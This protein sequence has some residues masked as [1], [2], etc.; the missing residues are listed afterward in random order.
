SDLEAYEALISK[1]KANVQGEPLQT[2]PI[3]K[4]IVEKP[5]AEV[6]VAGFQQAWLNLKDTHEFFGL[7]GKY[8]IAR[9]QAMRLAPEEHA[10]QISIDS[11]KQ[12][13]ENVSERELEI[14]VFIG[15]RGCI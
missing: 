8:G 14:M 12:I 6:D 1:Y 7:L 4:T 15:S 9:R 3:D 2:S 5:D 13:I 10:K 11:L